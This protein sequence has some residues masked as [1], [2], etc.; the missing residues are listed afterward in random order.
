M[1]TFQG[2]FETDRR[3]EIISI[4][5]TECEKDHGLLGSNVLKVDTEIQIY[6]LEA[7]ENKIG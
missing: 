2:N 5:V 1:G 7:E 4:A 3:F 6:S